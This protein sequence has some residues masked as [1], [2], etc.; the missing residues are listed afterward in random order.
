MSIT[1]N[2]QEAKTNLSHL[3]AAATAGDEVIIANSGVPLVKLEPVSKPK[4]RQL[5]FV[6]G[7]LPD[8]FFDELPEEE[9]KAWEL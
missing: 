3:V 1:M 9:L 6:Q 7:H 5:G 8:S 4:K 2:I